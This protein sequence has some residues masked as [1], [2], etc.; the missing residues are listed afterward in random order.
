[1][2]EVMVIKIFFF[3]ITKR[4][5]FLYHVLDVLLK[6]MQ[7]TIELLKADP[8]SNVNLIESLEAS[9]LVLPKCHVRSNVLLLLVKLQK[10][11][12]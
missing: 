6:N 9:P 5:P 3:L 7:A 11:Y 10:L 1:M 4:Y 2:T 12:Y 8:N